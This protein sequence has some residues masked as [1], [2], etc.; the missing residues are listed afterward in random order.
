MVPEGDCLFIQTAVPLPAPV[1]GCLF[2]DWTVS[3]PDTPRGGGDLTPPDFSLRG[4][5]HG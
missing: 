1:P 5:F 4:V 3:Q 2:H